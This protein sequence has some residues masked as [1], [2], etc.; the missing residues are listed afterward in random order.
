VRSARRTGQPHTPPLLVRSGPRVVRVHSVRV[1]DGAGVHVG[2]D[3]PRSDSGIRRTRERRERDTF[4][5]RAH[6][7]A[8]CPTPAAS[9]ARMSDE[10]AAFAPAIPAA[11]AAPFSALTAVPG[12]PLPTSAAAILAFSPYA[13]SARARYS[14]R[15][16]RSQL[17]RWSSCAPAP[18]H[19]PS[20]SDPQLVVLKLTRLV[21]VVVGSAY[22]RAGLCGSVPASQ[23]SQPA[24]ASLTRLDSRGR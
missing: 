19:S 2:V 13:R 10:R 1:V 6:G 9:F 23:E 5:E 18:A 12:R 8:S 15:P 4:R 21:G 22:G 24:E 3:V 11:L 17:W 14:P 7:A 16:R 20:R